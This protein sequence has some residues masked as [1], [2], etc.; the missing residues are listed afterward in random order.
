MENSHVN[1]RRDHVAGGAF[2]LLGLAVL[3]LSSDL[4]FGTLASPGAG[5]LPLLLV[6][7]LMVFGAI[8][9]LRALESPPL[10]SIDWA[11]VRH[12]LPV[13]A[14]ACVAASTYT[15]LGFLTVTPLMLFVLIYVVERRPLLSAVTFSIGATVLAYTVFGLLLKTPLPRGFMGL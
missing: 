10:A 5:M 9:V 4:P 8:L 14:V 13:L 15:T 12:A 3:A 7:L 11:D 2:V 1:L 6:G